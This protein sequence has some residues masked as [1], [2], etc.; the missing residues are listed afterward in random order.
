[1]TAPSGAASRGDDKFI[2]RMPPG[3]R[4][5][6]KD[7]A[8]ANLRSMNSELLYHLTRIYGSAAGPQAGTDNPT[9]DH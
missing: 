6:I 2:V 1:M 4:D 9:A 8:A 3:L 7:V 5:R